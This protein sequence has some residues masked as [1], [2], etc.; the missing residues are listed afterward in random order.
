MPARIQKR[1]LDITKEIIE[2][3]KNG[4]AVIYL[5]K[6]YSIST[7]TFYRILKKKPELGAAY[8]AAKN[9]IHNHLVTKLWESKDPKSAMFLLERRFPNL[10]GRYKANEATL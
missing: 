1:S 4:E 2:C 3:V 9:D 5:C 6:K 7:E 8:N 10:Y